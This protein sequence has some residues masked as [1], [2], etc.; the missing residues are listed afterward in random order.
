MKVNTGFGYFV[1]N[2]EIKFKYELPI[3]EHPDPVGYE[4]VEVANKE[5]LDAIIVIKD[6]VNSQEDL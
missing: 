3:G 5:A 6:V 1:K 4:V 2:G